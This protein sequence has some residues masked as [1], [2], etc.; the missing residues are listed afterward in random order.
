MSL[1]LVAATALVAPAPAHAIAIPNPLDLGLPDPGDLVGKVFEFF[2]S[3]FFGIETTVTQDAVHWLLAAPVYTDTSAYADLNELRASIEVAAWALLTLVFRVAA[4]R[5]YASGFTSAGSYEAVEA[6]VRG[7]LA[8]GVLALYAQVFGSLAIAANSLTYGITHT[9]VVGSG[10][11]KLLG[12]STVSSFTPLGLGSIAA[13]VAVVIFVLL[14]VTKIVLATLLALLFIAAP[15]AIALW[16]LP[17]TS[18]LAQDGAAVAARRVAVAGR[19]GAVLLAV[20]GHRRV[21]ADAGR[22]V[23]IAAGQAVG[24]GRGAVRRVQGAAAAR[25]PSDARRPDA[26]ARRRGRARPDVRARRDARAAARR[27]AARRAS[28][29]AS[30]RRAAAGA[31]GLMRHPT[32]KHLEARLRLGAFSLGQWAQITAAAIAATV[33]GGYLSPFPTQVTIFVA[34]VGAGLPVAV[35]YGA[36][37]LQF[38]VAQFTRAAWRYWRA[39][40]RYLAGPGQ[41]TTGYV[42]VS[43]PGRRRRTDRGHRSRWGAAVGRLSRTT[44]AE[45]CGRGRR[46]VRGRSDR[47]R[48]PARHQRGRA[49]ARPASSAEEPARRCPRSSA[50]RSATRSGSSPHACRPASRCSS[51]SKRPRCASTRCLSTAA[52]KPS[53]PSARS[54]ATH[55]GRSDAMRRLHGALRESLERHA[56]EQAAVDVAYYVVVPYLPDQTNQLDWRQLLPTGRRRLGTAPLE[57]S[58]Q[59]HRRVARESLHLTDQIRGDLEALDLSTHLLSGPEILDL[60]WRRFNP[61]TADRTP[62]RRP[63][64]RE[65]RLEVVGELDAIADARAAANAAQTLRELVAALRDRCARSAPPARRSRSRAGAVRRDAPG[66]DGVRLAA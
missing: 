62:E 35:S 61:T 55:D 49:R 8:A 63:G 18:W 17:E 34:I 65:E 50:S 30:A 44:V 6:L 59:A 43:E 38:S 46:A 52:A 31:A 51:T 16:P 60:L 25:P 66:R 53:A 22:L 5:Y 41:P 13:V 7:A 1:A 45:P 21:G 56:D 54:A 2:F 42:V 9:P 58:L 27:A 37:G 12:A 57:R 32:Y 3:T 29:G 47:P 10:L 48:G 26:V 23:R 36:M 28:P 14:I 20:R 33:F 15:L 39:P 19:V 40:R 11:T 64:A 24:V 4:V